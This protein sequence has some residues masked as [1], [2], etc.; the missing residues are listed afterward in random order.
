[1]IFVI[2][3]ALICW[4]SIGQI[5]LLYVSPDSRYPIWQFGG[6]TP[7]RKEAFLPCYNKKSMMFKCFYL[8]NTA[9]VTGLITPLPTHPHIN[10]KGLTVWGKIK[11]KNDLFWGNSIS[12]VDVWLKSKLCYLCISTMGQIQYSFTGMDL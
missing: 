5:I 3:L 2:C 6:V 10:I 4:I 9:F 8:W 7:I 12:F 11:K 1:M